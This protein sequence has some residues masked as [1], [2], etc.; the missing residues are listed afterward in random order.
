MAGRFIAPS[1]Q[2][3]DNSGNILAGGKLFFYDSGTVVAKDTFSDPGGTTANA[4]P[5]I[6]DGAGRTP[7]IYLTGSYKLIIKDSAEVQ[8]ETRDPVLAADDTTKGFAVWN[9]VTVFSELDIVRAAN[10]FLYRSLADSNQNFEPSASAA[11]WSQVQLLGSYNANETYATGNTVVDSTGNIYKSRVDSNTGN[12]PATSPTEWA[13]SI[14]AVFG[15]LTADVINETTSGSGVTIEGVLVKD[16]GVNGTLG[17]TTP[18]TISAT[19]LSASGAA[20]TGPLTVTGALGVSGDV[21]LSANVGIG[22]TPTVQSSVNALEVGFVG[23]GIFSFDSNN[24]VL[25]SGGYFNSGDKY[26]I[27]SAAVS[28]YYQTAGEHRWN[29]AASGTAGNA[30]TWSRQ[31]TLAAAG[32]LTIVGALSK[33]SGSFRID[34]PLPELSETHQLVHSFTESPQADLLYSGT[35]KLVNGSAKV[36]LDEYHGMT[37]GTFVALNRNIRVFTTNETD[38]EP[39]RGYVEGNTLYISCQD[40]SCSDSVSW[41]VIGERHDQHMMDTGWTDEQGRVIVEPLKPAPEPTHKPV[42]RTVKVAIM[43]GDEQLMA[44][45]TVNV[46]EKIEFI[47]GVAT[48]IPATTE[49]QLKPQFETVGVFDT[50]GNPVYA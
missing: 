11:K 39:I 46:P 36:N 50:E 19:T 29:S 32:A 21:T 23:S 3:F 40:S 16:G 42:Q 13:T 43:D 45:E 2:Y 15:T 41:L 22:V 26:A 48:L 44:L 6:L 12:T 20:A 14:P 1:E 47:D 8:I 37:E 28:Q 34:H 10:N 27:S 38:W 9:A 24:T 17:A 18:S 49:E 30:I 4:N 7:D 31:M 33:G 35:T 25:M 5:V